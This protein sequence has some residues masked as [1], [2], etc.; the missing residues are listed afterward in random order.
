[1]DVGGD[2]ITAAPGTSRESP[3]KCRLERFMSGLLVVKILTEGVA[4]KK[5]Q[6]QEEGRDRQDQEARH[7]MSMANGFI[8]PPA[9]KAKGNLVCV[10]TSHRH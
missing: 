2:G 6:Q 4:G 3:K 8:P 9:P 7:A 1:M 10:K 5:D